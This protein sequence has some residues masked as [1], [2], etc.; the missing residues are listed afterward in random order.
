MGNLYLIRH[1]SVEYT[2]T[3]SIDL[4]IKLSQLGYQ[5]SNDLAKSWEIPLDRFYSSLLP[6]SVQTIR[7]LAD[8]FGQ[9]VISL[10]GLNELF[11]N[12]DAHTFHENIKTNPAFKYQGGE[13]IGQANQRFIKCLTQ[14]A[15]D[16]QSSSVAISVHGTVFS[17]FMI[18]QLGFPS[19]CFFHLSYPDLYEISYKNHKFDF[20][21][22][23]TK[24]LPLVSEN[25]NTSYAT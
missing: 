14:I 4:N 24:Y 6:R 10:K 16:N 18:H 11:Y 1:C 17:E 12:G 2:G 19:D 21:Q 15:K 25:L 23:H 9:T 8:K 7:P 22:R 3:P 13:S 5:Q 20:V